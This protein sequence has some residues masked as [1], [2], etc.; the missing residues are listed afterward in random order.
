M[1]KLESVLKHL[2]FPRLATVGAIA[3]IVLLIAV[4]YTQKPEPP[5][6]VTPPKVD[7]ARVEPTPVQ[8]VII[9]PEPVQELH[10]LEPKKFDTAKCKAAAKL[11]LV[12]KSGED[13]LRKAALLANYRHANTVRC[14]EKELAK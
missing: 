12:P 1:A 2:T 4:D 8:T 10:K 11:V 14:Y 13:E 7:Q 9:K 5:P 6:V 3:V